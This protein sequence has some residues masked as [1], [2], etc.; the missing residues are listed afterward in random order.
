[1]LFYILSG[2]LA[3]LIVLR[4]LKTRSFNEKSY[5]YLYLVLYGSL[6]GDRFFLIKD[7]P[8]WHESF[9]EILFIFGILW[10][11][12][13][14]AWKSFS[15]WR[16]QTRPLRELKKRQGPFHEIV[17]ASKLISQAKMGALIILERATSLEPWCQK[18]IRLDAKLSQELLFSVFTPPGALHDGAAIIRNACIS[19]C[20]VIV[21]LTKSPRFP[22]ELG[23]RH[24]AAVGFSETCDA[25]CLV[26]SEETGCFSLAD[27]GTL[28]Y[29]IPFEKLAEFLEQALRFRL[30]KNQ[31]SVR[32]L[33][34]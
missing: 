6:F 26:V 19:A 14:W 7:G 1:M 25:L 12:V 8:S 13:E 30:D 9:L 24:R 11:S 29:D 23:T 33:E 3:I 17:T 15:Q 4:A 21:P 20:G 16:T 28:F 2:I 18:G 32:T 27:R 34:V 10:F 22:K 5:L 31:P